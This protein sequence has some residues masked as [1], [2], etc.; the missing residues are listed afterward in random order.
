ME[1]YEMLIRTVFISFGVAGVLS[2]MISIIGNMYIEETEKNWA[3]RVLRLG[4][5]GLNVLALIVIFILTEG[6][7]AALKISIIC[8]VLACIC[9]DTVFYKNACFLNWVMPKV[10]EIE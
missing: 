7:P 5:V 1:Y 10:R 4:N 9:I 6:S 8:G 2:I 3:R